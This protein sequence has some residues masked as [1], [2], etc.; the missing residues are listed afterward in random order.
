[1]KFFKYDKHIPENIKFIKWLKDSLQKL[2]A[3]LS[4]SLNLT[5][6]KVIF[7]AAG[8]WRELIC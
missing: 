3:L 8:E 5:E 1:M 4:E 2:S 6:F 7:T